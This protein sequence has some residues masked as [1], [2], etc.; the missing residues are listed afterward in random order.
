MSLGEPEDWYLTS[1]Q[2]KHPNPIIN[3]KTWLRHGKNT[4][5][6]IIDL[7]LL[8]GTYS[9]DKMVD[10]LNRKFGSKKSDIQR[11]SRIKDHFTHLQEGTRLDLNNGRKPHRLKI[12]EFDGTWSFALKEI[13]ADEPLFRMAFEQDIPYHDIDEQDIPDPDIEDNA[14]LDLRTGDVYWIADSDKDAATGWGIPENENRAMRLKIMAEP[15]R[16]PNI[17]GLSHGEHHDILEDF[18]ASDWIKDEN[19]KDFANASYTRNIWRWIEKVKDYEGILENYESFKQ[20][21]INRR[22][23]D[24]FRGYGIRVKWRQGTEGENQQQRERFAS[25]SKVIWIF[26]NRLKNTK[27]E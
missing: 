15:D 3:G 9:L 16:Y 10:K 8:D 27:D 14:F 25:N 7:M 20:N 4:Q 1:A 26:K 6:G 19:M 17:P 24:F 2:L 11:K 21:E 22:I 12:Y 18:L 13:S 23:R 5:A